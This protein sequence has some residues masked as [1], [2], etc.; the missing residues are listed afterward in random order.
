[1]NPKDVQEAF[2]KAGRNDLPTELDGRQG[3]NPLVLAYRQQLRDA[4][5]KEDPRTDSEITLFLGDLARQQQDIGG[6][7]GI[8]ALNAE[9]RYQQ[10]RDDYLDL[11]LKRQDSGMAQEFGGGLEQAS[12]GMVATGAGAYRMTDLPGGEA[13]WEFGKEV[14]GNA[15]RASV[16][17]YEDLFR[18]NGISWNAASQYVPNIAG[19]AIPS[20]VEAIGAF[21]LGSASGGYGAAAVYGTKKAAQQGIKAE[22]RRD[23]RQSLAKKVIDKKKVYGPNHTMVKQGLKK[24]DDLMDVEDYAAELWRIRGGIGASSL[25]SLALNSGEIYNTLREEGFSHDESQLS[26]LAYGSIAALPDSVLPAWVGKSF[27]KRAGL[28][29]QSQKAKDQAMSWLG[30]Q[31]TKLKNSTLGKVGLGIAFEGTTE[32]FQE[33]INIAAPAWK[34]GEEVDWSDPFLKSRVINAS[35]IGAVAGAMGGGLAALGGKS[36][37]NDQESKTETLP[38]SNLPVSSISGMS[39][40]GSAPIDTYVPGS[41]VEF[42]GI[43]GDLQV[44]RVVKVTPEGVQIEPIIEFD[45]P[46]GSSGVR[47]SRVG[48]I[49]TI[50]E[51][52]IVGTVD[53]KKMEEASEILGEVPT[54]EAA[55]ELTEDVELPSAEQEA[56]I[57]NR[58]EL[59]AERA[60][61]ETELANPTSNT[62]VDELN[63]RLRQ[64]DSLLNP[65]PP[66]TVEKQLMADESVETEI[67]WDDDKYFYFTH[68]TDEASLENIE[69]NGFDLKRSGGGIE[70]S[71]KRHKD[72]TDALARIEGESDHKGH[73]SY[74]VFRIEKSK[75]DKSRR[76]GGISD[77]T[78]DSGT[79]IVPNE[80]VAG[81]VR[82]K[83]KAP[84]TTPATTPTTTPKLTVSQN[85]KTKKWHVKDDKGNIVGNP[86]GYKTRTAA[87]GQANR[88]TTKLAQKL[89]TQPEQ[90]KTAVQGILDFLQSF[91]VT[92]EE[93]ENFLADLANK[94]I[95][96]NF[97]KQNLDKLAKALADQLSI[98]ISGSDLYRQFSYHVL[99]NRKS[100]DFHKE[101]LKRFIKLH[102]ENHSDVPYDEWIN[103][104]N[105]KFLWYKTGRQLFRETIA[106]ILSGRISEKV[107]E[108]MG[109]TKAFL[110]KVKEFIRKVLSKL[111]DADFSVKSQGQYVS[112]SEFF[113]TLTEDVFAGRAEKYRIGQNDVRKDVSYDNVYDV[114]ESLNNAGWAGSVVK[115]LAR[116]VKFA[117]TGSLSIAGKGVIYRPKGEAIHDLDYVFDGTEEELDAAIKEAHPNA[118]RLPPF[119]SASG[120]MNAPYII[121]KEGYT[122]EVGESTNPNDAYQVSLKFINQSTGQ[123]ENNVEYV[124]SDFF[125]REINK[126]NTYVH[127]WNSDGENVPV[128]MTTPEMS[129]ESKVEYGRTKDIFDYQNYTPTPEAQKP[130]G[131]ST[132]AKPKAAKPKPSKE[133]TSLKRLHAKEKKLLRKLEQE[134]KTVKNGGKFKSTNSKAYKKHRDKI[135]D[136]RAKVKKLKE[137][138]DQLSA[139]A[140][141]QAVAP[142]EEEEFVDT[143]TETPFDK[144]KPV[145]SQPKQTKAKSKPVK[146]N[147]KLVAKK[148]QELEKA[149]E[150]QNLAQN[151][152]NQSLAEAQGRTNIDS[153]LKKDL[154]AK[155]AILI[156]KKRR[157]RIIQRDLLKAK[158]VDL[159]DPMVQFDQIVQGWVND[160]TLSEDEKKVLKKAVQSD[161]KQTDSDKEKKLTQAKRQG[162]KKSGA[163]L[164]TKSPTGQDNEYSVVEQDDINRS[165]TYKSE[166]GRDY[167]ARKK[168]IVQYIEKETDL[169][170]SGFITPE[171]LYEQIDKE[172]SEIE[173]K[174]NRWKLEVA[175][176][177]LQDLRKKVGY[178]DDPKQIQRIRVLEIHNNFR[179]EPVDVQYEIADGK[180][181]TKPWQIHYAIQKRR[182]TDAKGVERGGDG[183]AVSGSVDATNPVSAALKLKSKIEG[184]VWNRITSAGNLSD[185]L[186]AEGV[187]DHLG[188][189]FISTSYKANTL[190]KYYYRARKGGVQANTPLAFS[191]DFEDG[192][193]KRQIAFFIL[194]DD[195]GII[196]ITDHTGRRIRVVDEAGVVVRDPSSISV[197]TSDTAIQVYRKKN[198]NDPEW[199]TVGKVIDV[200]GLSEDGILSAL[201]DPDNG[202]G[203][204]STG[205]ISQ[206]SRHTTRGV[207]VF[208]KPDGGVV[209]TGLADYRTYKA[210]RSSAQ[211]RLGVL[212]FLK[213]GKNGWSKGD[214]QKDFIEISKAS[215]PAILQEVIDAGYNPIAVLRLERFLK[216]Q[217]K[218]IDS[219]AGYPQ[220][221]EFDNR[222]AYQEWLDNIR[223]WGG[224]GTRQTV[225]EVSTRDVVIQNADKIVEAIAMANTP[226]ALNNLLK[227][228][229]QNYVPAGGND[230]QR[231]F[232]TG[233][234]ATIL[235]NIANT[236]DP[237]V[238]SNFFTWDNIYDSISQIDNT[239]AGYLIDLAESSIAA[240][241]QS[242][243]DQTDIETD[244]FID[245]LDESVEI[246]EEHLKKAEQE[247]REQWKDTT[248]ALPEPPLSEDQIRE[249]GILDRAKQ[250]AEE[251]SGKTKRRL[252][253][254]DHPVSKSNHLDQQFNQLLDTL[255]KSGINVQIFQKELDSVYGFLRANN[256]EINE[257]DGLIRMVV[258]DL[259]RP[260]GTNLLSLYHEATH[261]VL[262]NLP[263]ADRA[264]ML[265]AIHQTNKQFGELKLKKRLDRAKKKYEEGTL[266]AS[267]LA[268][269]QSAEE[270]LV[271]AVAQN[272]ANANIKKGTI[273]AIIRKLRELF[274]RIYYAFAQAAGLD[275]MTSA[276]AAERYLTVKMEQFVARD[277]ETLPPFLT[278]LNGPDFTKG[279]EASTLKVYDSSDIP[280]LLDPTTQNLKNPELAPT[281][282]SIKVNRD[283]FITGK[284]T[285]YTNKVRRGINDQLWAEYK[286]ER[287]TV[288]GLI[289]FAGD[290]TLSALYSDMGKNGL[291]FPDIKLLSNKDMHSRFGGDVA[292]YHYYAGISP[293][294]YMSRDFGF[295][296]NVPTNETEKSVYLQIQKKALAEVL[297]H[298]LTHHVSKA[299][300]NDA[301]ESSKIGMTGFAPK[302]KQAKA[303]WTELYNA[304]LRF[305]DDP[306]MYGL[307]SLEEFVSEARNNPQFQKYLKNIPL[308]QNL[309]KRF[310]AKG[311]MW[312]AF[313]FALGRVVQPN[314]NVYS[315]TSK[316]MK[317]T[318]EAG[319]DAKQSRSL[320]DPLLKIIKDP[321]ITPEER[322]LYFVPGFAANSIVSRMPS[323]RSRKALREAQD[324]NIEE[325]VV[326]NGEEV[327]MHYI[328]TQ[329]ERME[330]LGESLAPATRYLLAFPRSEKNPEP[331]VSRVINPLTSL[332]EGQ[333]RRPA[334]EEMWRLV[335]TPSFRDWYGDWMAGTQGEGGNTVPTGY[336]K[337][338]E[339]FEPRFIYH[340]RGGEALSNHGIYVMDSQVNLP[341]R[342]SSNL[343]PGKIT[344]KAGGQ[345]DPQVSDFELEGLTPQEDQR[346][347]SG[348]ANPAEDSSMAFFGSQ[349]PRVAAGWARAFHRN[350]NVFL[351]MAIR[352]RYLKSYYENF[353]MA[354]PEYIRKKG[355]L[356]L[357]PEIDRYA[358]LDTIDTMDDAGGN[359]SPVILTSV[360][361]TDAHRVED[362]YTVSTKLMSGKL[363]S[364][365][366]YRETTW[367][368]DP[369]R[370]DK[371]VGRMFYLPGSVSALSNS[372]I[373][374]NQ[375]FETFTHSRFKNG[376][377]VIENAKGEL[378]FFAAKRPLQ[379]I[380]QG[381]G[382]KSV[383]SAFS[384]WT[385]A[386]PGYEVQDQQG[387]I[388]DE[389]PYT[390]APSE[391]YMFTGDV[392]IEDLQDHIEA[393]DNKAFSDFAQDMA[394]NTSKILEKT[395]NDVQRSLTATEIQVRTRDIPSRRFTEETEDRVEMIERGA[396][397]VTTEETESYTGFIK[398]VDRENDPFADQ[399]TWEDAANFYDVDVDELINFNSPIT[400]RNGNTTNVDPSDA[401]IQD[402]ILVPLNPNNVFSEGIILPIFSSARNPLIL[403]EGDQ[404]GQAYNADFLVNALQQITGSRTPKFITET[405]IPMMGR[406][407]E[408]KPQEF[409]DDIHDLSKMYDME[410]TDT[411]DESKFTMD[412][413]VG[414]RNPLVAL[415]RSAIGFNRIANEDGR[416]TNALQ[417]DESALRRMLVTPGGLIDESL[418]RSAPD[419]LLGDSDIQ[420]ITASEVH[421]YG[422]QLPSGRDA[423]PVLEYYLSTR[424][425]F[426]GSG[427]VT[428]SNDSAFDRTMSYMAQADYSKGDMAAIAAVI[429]FGDELYGKQDT[430]N[431]GSR[432]PDEGEVQEQNR[433]IPFDANN[434]PVDPMRDQL[435]AFRYTISQH[436]GLAGIPHVRLL[437]LITLA[438]KLKALKHPRIKS[439]SAPFTT[440]AS[441]PQPPA[442]ME[443]AKLDPNDKFLE[444]AK[445]LD[446]RKPI[447]VD[448]DRVPLS[449]GGN[450]I[451]NNGKLYKLD[452]MDLQ[453][454]REEVFGS[455][456]LNLTGV[457]NPPKTFIQ[458]GDQYEKVVDGEVK[459]VGNV[460]YAVAT[461][462]GLGQTS[463]GMGVNTF[464]WDGGARLSGIT[465]N[466]SNTKNVDVYLRSAT[467][468]SQGSTMPIKTGMY[469]GSTKVSGGQGYVDRG[470]TTQEQKTA[471]AT[472]L[473]LIPD[474]FIS[475]AAEDAGMN[476]EGTTQAT[477]EELVSAGPNMYGGNSTLQQ[478]KLPDDGVVFD[479]GIWQSSV[480][481]RKSARSKRTLYAEAA[482]GAIADYITGGLVASGKVTKDGNL[483]VPKV[484]GMSEVKDIPSQRVHTKTFM[485][486]PNGFEEMSDV[487]ALK[488]KQLVLDLITHGIADY[489]INNRDGHAGN[490]G[491]ANG[492]IVSFDKGQAFKYYTANTQGSLMES[493]LEGI[494]TMGTEAS[495]I[496][497]EATEEDG[498]VHFLETQYGKQVDIGNPRI[499]YDQLS[500]LARESNLK[501]EEILRE[502]VPVIQRI[503]LLRDTGYSFNR[504]KLFK[505]YSTDKD[506]N[507]DDLFQENILAEFEERMSNIENKIGDLIVHLTGKAAKVAPNTYFGQTPGDQALLSTEGMQKTGV[508]QYDAASPMF[509]GPSFGK[510]GAGRSGA[511]GSEYAPEVA[512][513]ATIRLEADFDPSTPQAFITKKREII[514]SVVPAAY[515]N[516]MSMYSPSFSLSDIN[517]DQ[518]IGYRRKLISNMMTS[519]RSRRSDFQDEYDFIIA[520][521]VTDSVNGDQLIFP[522]PAGTLKNAN[523]DSF[524]AGSPHFKQRLDIQD[525]GESDVSAITQRVNAF[526][527]T[528]AA[529][530]RMLLETIQDGYKNAKTRGFKGSIEQFLKRYFKINPLNNLKIIAERDARVAD[531]SITDFDGNPA[532][533]DR[534]LRFA[535]ELHSKTVSQVS[536]AKR[537]LE[538]SLE[539]KMDD[540][541][542]AAEEQAMLESKWRDATAHEK[543][544]Q[545]SIK[546]LIKQYVR[547]IDGQVDM[548]FTKGQLLGAIK[549]VEGVLKGESLSGV[550]RDAL[551]DI[552]DGNVQVFSY[553]QAMAELGL[554][555]ANATET[556]IV[557][558]INK[559]KRPE[560]LA[561]QNNKPLMATLVAFSKDKALQ[562]ALLEARTTKD[563]DESSK[564]DQE[565][566]KTRRLS[567]DQLKDLTK[568]IKG[569]RRQVSK[570]YKVR[571]AYAKIRLAH[572]RK[573]RSAESDKQDIK[574]YSEIL[575]VLAE[576]ERNLQARLGVG[577]N[578]TAVPGETYMHMEKVKGEWVAKR[579]VYS[580]DATDAN[581]KKIN[582][583]KFLNKAYLDEQKKK[584]KGDE[585]F[586]RML[587]EVNYQLSKSIVHREYKA[588]HMGV[589][590][591]NLSTLEQRLRAL[592]QSGVQVSRMVAEFRRIQ[593]NYRVESENL[594]AKW[595]GAFGE[596]IKASNMDQSV[597]KEMI[598]DTGIYWIENMPEY[599]DDP[600]ALYN[601]VYSE[602]SKLMKAGGKQPKETLKPALEK[603]W[604]STQAVADFQESIANEHNVLVE[605][606]SMQWSNPLTGKRENLLR[607]RI[608][609]GLITIPRRLKGEV[610]GVVTKIMNK[611]GWENE[612][613]FQE[614]GRLSKSA[615]GEDQA[616][617]EMM[618]LANNLF[619][620]DA[621]VDS[622]LRPLL[623]KP[624]DPLFT[625]PAKRGSKAKHPIPQDEVMSAWLQ[626]DGD[627]SVFV[628]ELFLNQDADPQDLPLFAAQIIKELRSIY[629]M[630]KGVANKAETSE[631]NPSTHMPHRMMDARTNTIFPREWLEYDT[632][633]KVDQGIHISKLASVAAFGRDSSV[634]AGMLQSAKAEANLLYQPLGELQQD[635]AYLALTTE[636]QRKKYIV[637]RLGKDAY[638]SARKASRI[639]REVDD[640]SRSLIDLFAAPGGGFK[641]VRVVEEL[642]GFNRDFVLRTPKSGLWQTMSG[643][644]YTQR[645]GYGTLSARTSGSFIYNLIRQTFGS[646]FG[647][648][649]GI[650]LV[651]ATEAGRVINYLRS[652][653]GQYDL[654][655]KEMFSNRG[656]EG[657]GESLIKLSRQVRD[658][659]DR[660]HL[661]LPG[662]K[663]GQSGFAAF[664]PLSPFKWMNNVIGTA[665]AEASI[666]T[667]RLVV[668][669]A[670]QY[671]DSNPRVLGD[672][673]F[674]FTLN[675]LGISGSLLGGNER[676]LEY[677]SDTWAEHTGQSFLDLVKQ[678]YKRKQR[679]EEIFSKED[680]LVMY[681]TAMDDINLEGGIGSTPVAMRTNP[682]LRVAAPLLTWA[683]GKTN[684]VNKSFGTQEGRYTLNSVLKG[685]AGMGAITMPIGIAATMLMDE[686]DE[687]ILGKRSNLREVD[688]VNLF[689][690]FAM[691]NMLTNKDG[692]GLAI[693]ERLARA[694]NTY[695]LGAEAAYGL[696]AWTDPMQGQ[697]SL[698]VD[699]VLIYSQLSNFRDAFVNIMHSGWYMNYEDGKRLFDAVAGQA[700]AHFA[701]TVNNLLYPAFEGEA[702]RV[703]R[704]DAFNYLRAAGRS[705][706]V[707]LKKSG[708]STS[709]TPLTSRIRQ[710]QLAAYGDDPVE[711]NA[712]LQ[713][714]IEVATEMGKE[715]PLGSI[716]RSWKAREPMDLFQRKLTDDET[717]LVFRHMN[718]RGRENV[719]DVIRLH[720]KYLRFLAP[721][722][723]VGSRPRMKNLY[724]SEQLR[725]SRLMYLNL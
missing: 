496:K 355:S 82:S 473:H 665:I 205:L 499:I 531:S 589:I 648:T 516:R 511:F 1:M 451:V 134:G 715:D 571:D 521:A 77:L 293:T 456:L 563:M 235:A 398:K 633:T 304:V 119:R 478:L 106:D 84:A 164:K 316:L 441:Q 396:T 193:G 528:Q 630:T 15:P 98:L 540:I 314:A 272:L 669:R 578:F 680:Y 370:T 434:N 49:I 495:E 56:R 621:V 537:N 400:D 63:I 79:T 566:K 568:E 411:Q 10:F 382:V 673:N 668:T 276:S 419:E 16:R 559:S 95:S 359:W 678:A 582:R 291:P 125:L 167:N 89:D 381:K 377:I 346:T 104:K 686:Y 416:Q 309:I 410:G 560:L 149:I 337:H 288:G 591:R 283:N 343:V 706:K 85:R 547:G 210:E 391:A 254:G 641:D 696:M 308:P 707:P 161:N 619:A 627:F 519:A 129:L 183:V 579:S 649:L 420:E 326:I 258:N 199:A 376:L 292:R 651:Q 311:A 636:K 29:G 100:S 70:N 430:A 299:V 477:P 142:E 80:Y 174:T 666:N 294:I 290:A 675:H 688:P 449:S 692:Q 479:N 679:K 616:Y 595:E 267:Q 21:F 626:S 631:F 605:D 177:I 2:A 345:L 284:E 575:R 544:A 480:I 625:A 195:S 270:V 432:Y 466:E 723:S 305:N 208:E 467:Q 220:Q 14:Q 695:G 227:V 206:K 488:D 243:A 714:A 333:G 186:N 509:Y 101:Q 35:I 340:G 65:T 610:I 71:V 660:V 99:K 170:R 690:G 562:M 594:S 158:G 3:A 408:Y 145:G 684:A 180:V 515:A 533:T 556:E 654:T 185:P 436:A 76:D 527:G 374:S 67:Q 72:S 196:H 86:K 505:D 215:R 212:G 422:S 286:D 64:L 229:R 216:G 156:D 331:P 312:D 269:I 697:R 201:K 453:Q 530:N 476:L 217:D 342:A 481:L 159:T 415:N 634:L 188:V 344:D 555:Y 500:N 230:L 261:F 53:S 41:M 51:N 548:T 23:L 558:E 105:A 656:V 368:F 334:D 647:E 44:G 68:V 198:D 722:V 386:D 179:R 236:I 323:A 353:A 213:S 614:I 670:M 425:G 364:D 724:A 176:D 27:L 657:N 590:N 117:L 717:E 226:D 551:Y 653:P 28:V 592:G 75:F 46:S 255:N 683:T 650:P 580:V 33:F 583:V 265:Q 623:T 301:S 462:I 18:A 192:R 4:T 622:F 620:N 705:A 296:D 404:G 285:N 94:N 624:G 681:Q 437:G 700:P 239:P 429:R 280:D 9:N 399:P 564:I 109:F 638:E 171:Q 298:E 24:A 148:E 498:I 574:I 701:Q 557:S 704:V 371:A 358:P 599:A 50:P 160:P 110:Q 596:A 682:I 96:L 58:E 7:Q 315:V 639:Q 197:P 52:T 552:F 689:P 393:V 218:N 244:V 202:G 232:R 273:R 271:E 126:E 121:P 468:F 718:Q 262:D 221:I 644:D 302:A 390:D 318:L 194:Q 234:S 282:Q 332:M 587:E 676:T 490:F 517:R 659:L 379:D 608:K 545:E 461:P 508:Y 565:I 513:P 484:D 463:E 277:N 26:A 494:E 266:S 664:T 30:G 25:N 289:E 710:M 504:K 242:I 155:R 268:E 157:T 520:G 246:T 632:F 103:T 603:L 719:M 360:L 635:P 536:K 491:I 327:P 572:D 172:F 658:G 640:I 231:L 708:M 539:K 412:P 274:S 257:A 62:P 87:R 222:D 36:A 674:K 251:E 489:I 561:L 245:E 250:I 115:R 17:K 457:L 325:T 336:F 200:D 609:Y 431:R 502:L 338:E 450:V 166:D 317:R 341:T 154:R 642:V 409:Y 433:Y 260:D 102:Q 604:R 612:N 543:N 418:T 414:L 224:K 424:Y 152:Y 39:G 181:A 661:Q 306:S 663:S 380:L 253:D 350:T 307:T 470:P 375:T 191:K 78:L 693:L 406:Q 672:P 725:Q 542:K 127:N 698:G 12:R 523:N 694:G 363:G 122:V 347:A 225:T 207:I 687:E 348:K 471:G 237:R 247:L 667:W 569:I 602:I 356:P 31:A 426:F 573:M 263:Q 535:G 549:E 124:T 452:F 324:I 588:F 703:K 34:R 577:Y 503:K 421:K 469:F 151:D 241:D 190:R 54:T 655:Y 606:P 38:V 73:K 143:E 5:G 132:G 83:D 576:K 144:L 223:Q 438:N 182:Y 529:S 643:L 702:R 373:E 209:T 383:N 184:K 204:T 486:M 584:G 275:P 465:F 443:V 92:I 538:I 60:S 248:W 57:Q 384:A 442:R 518:A 617:N 55:P 203:G 287:M 279:E 677:L 525:E 510:K 493:N 366:D 458:V 601:A 459:Y 335:R 554:D 175:D 69:K 586:N 321:N 120:I 107:A 362:P 137:Q 141:K 460:R 169:F 401:I 352:S 162:A 111:S 97:D 611:A 153:G 365:T 446:S 354:T 385:K 514:N 506:G 392:L 512:S 394:D 454:A 43:S 165:R 593:Q 118:V 720:E 397:P 313:N 427:T 567:K 91:G 168:S 581:R 59:E 435:E 546:N 214:D 114:D 570:V 233:D 339:T 550:Y 367:G 615:M 637:S 123:V 721:S 329:G 357:D 320:V 522:F 440:T 628:K 295:V 150:D 413:W 147:K 108:D 361:S 395:M 328:E 61:I 541:Q 319:A 32:G 310:G 407:G 173:H 303:D 47:A 37:A 447:K 8:T 66:E 501:P 597:F 81:F 716:V 42:T 439:A 534:T 646:L 428:Y 485:D 219:I 187:F 13:V 264:R 448:K 135:L 189:M 278:W 387:N 11:D 228:I 74:V 252:S 20:L 48:E 532:M 492:R 652:N 113:N 138:L 699:R 402:D 349:Y 93:S 112:L 464:N 139:K 445:Q 211:G 607:R 417:V 585:P 178:S 90:V 130:K 240:R 146:V 259:L 685:V 133:L 712:I 297:G 372:F 136:Q 330:Y 671:I 116:N 45:Q 709:P 613:V 711:F 40:Y 600:Q 472:F 128:T 300:F 483:D 19:Q 474:E 629:H 475:L 405:A 281:G 691:Y 526:D 163:K 88:L 388:I 423:S 389:V 22:L 662:M 497:A 6:N 351:K 482:G 249:Y 322:L 524:D 131:V 444:V 140:P 455:I 553:I 645:L 238:P 487:S 507:T 378:N 369:S 598:Y 618:G 256:A 403:N 713:E